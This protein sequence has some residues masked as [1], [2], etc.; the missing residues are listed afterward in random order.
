MGTNRRYAESI[1]RRMDERIAQQVMR[2][3]EPDSLT[4]AE[5]QRDTEPVTRTP[6]ARPVTAWVRYGKM[7]MRVEAEAVAWTSNA[8]A[9]RWPGPDGVVHKAWVWASAVTA[10]S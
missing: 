1:D 8:V 7:P 6:V 4:D 5:M 2:E 3:T 10:R 9:I